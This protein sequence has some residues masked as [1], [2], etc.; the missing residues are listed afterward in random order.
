MFRD[1]AGA[2]Q[3]LRFC[4][5]GAGNTAVDFIVFFLLNMA[6]AQYLTAQALSYTAGVVNS[7]FF[8]RAW[9]FRVAR[10]ASFPEAVSFIMVNGLSLSAAS[11]LLYI[12]YDVSHLDL[13]L[14]K[15][16]ATGAG[17]IVN[18]MG[19]RLWVFAENGKARGEVS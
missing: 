15:C 12:L 7:Y 8:N 9:T 19:N 10:K 17:A 4:T 18:F 2:L 5:V 1:R 3:F 14:S 13:W 16:I 6:G 11:G